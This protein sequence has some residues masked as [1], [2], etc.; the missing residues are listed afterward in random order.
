MLEEFKKTVTEEACKW[1]EQE[2]NA[3]LELDGFDEEQVSTND[4]QSHLNLALL[5]L[6]DDNVSISSFEH[7]ISLE[8]Y[9]QGR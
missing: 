5:D 9:L 2:V 3:P 1:A 6:E 7:S 8:D 4:I